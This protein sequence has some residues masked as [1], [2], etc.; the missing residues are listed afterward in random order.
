MISSAGPGARSLAT[1]SLFLGVC[2][3][4]QR[5]KTPPTATA[6]PEQIT[7]REPHTK[8]PGRWIGG[9]STGPAIML[10]GPARER[11]D[12]TAAD[13]DAFAIGSFP[14]RR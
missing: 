12:D 3:S 8:P 5:I 9:S 14:V 4:A 7:R 13:Q 11:E 2:P 6:A 1:P 10:V